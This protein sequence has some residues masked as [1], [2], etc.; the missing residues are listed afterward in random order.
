MKALILFSFLAL[1]GCGGIVPPKQ[2]NNFTIPTPTPT[3]VATPT[4]SPTP[5]P[6]PVVRSGVAFLGDSTSA[7]WDLDTYFPGKGYVN[8]GIGGNT[9]AQILARLPDL[10][11]GKQACTSR[12]GQA[13]FTC[14]SI[15]PPA[16]VMIFAGWNNVLGT[17]DPVQ[18]A[19]DIQKM[20]LLCQQAGVQPIVSTIYLYD[21][22]ESVAPPSFGPVFDA[23]INTVNASI[24]GF[25]VT[26]IDLEALFQ[27]QS[28]YTI[29]GVHPN[30]TG[31]TAMQGAYNLVLPH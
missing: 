20:I 14:E 24:R 16:T 30:P 19:N 8:A 17:L 13:P 15:P 12:N 21:S 4:P 11:S 2:V 27:G 26:Y 25:G 31:Y 1:M 3:P 28:D 7:L 18:T 9:T 10:L 29:D 5:T 23:E 22:A 6:T